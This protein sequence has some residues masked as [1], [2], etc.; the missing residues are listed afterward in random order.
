M[1]DHLSGGHR[2][3]F[4]PDKP[5]RAICDTKLLRPAPTS[6]GGGRGPVWRHNGPPWEDLRP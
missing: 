4:N 5:H 2:E 1:F 6:R 3:F